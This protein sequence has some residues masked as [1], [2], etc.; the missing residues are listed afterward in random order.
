MSIATPSD[1]GAP[2]F[3]IDEYIVAK[4]HGVFEQTPGL[5]AVWIHGSR[6]RGYARLESDID[7]AID[8][9]SLDEQ[10]FSRLKRRVEDLELVYRTDIVWLQKIK[11]ERFRN[12]VQ[13]YRQLFWQP[14]RHA[15]D[16]GAVGGVVLKDFQSRVL[17]A[18][19]DYIEEL[20]QKA[21]NALAV[22]KALRA[23][24]NMAD[25]AR[26]AG[27]FPKQAWQALNARRMLP[28]VC[29]LNTTIGML[30]RWHMSTALRS[31]TLRRSLITRS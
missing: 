22:Q 19:G 6:A 12:E 23:M 3:G 15:A 29:R 1:R 24:E 16:V 21:A 26:E 31:M 8:G 5:E 7:L 2:F 11:D 14:R 20:K 28:A 13:T 25:L 9:A 18:L 27:D 4:L 17:D 30:L 10:A